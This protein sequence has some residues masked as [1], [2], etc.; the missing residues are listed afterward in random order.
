MLEKIEEEGGCKELE[1]EQEKAGRE[2]RRVIESG[3]GKEDVK[4]RWRDGATVFFCFKTVQPS[5]T[6]QPP[7]Y[8]TALWVQMN[9]F[10]VL[11]HLL[12]SHRHI[13]GHELSV[14]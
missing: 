12:L 10:N 3:R 6:Y 14:I 8:S 7:P 9:N 5:Q 2:R 13:I 4:K 1:G 11:V